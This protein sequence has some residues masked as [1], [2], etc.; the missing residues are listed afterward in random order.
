MNRYKLLAVLFYSVSAMP[1]MAQQYQSVW[2]KSEPEIT[3][4]IMSRTGISV[5]SI[6]ESL[7]LYRDILGMTPFYERTGLQDPRLVPFSGMTADQTMNLVVLRTETKGSA[8][9]HAGYIGLSEIREADGSIAKLPTIT[10]QQ[11]H[12]GS[13]T[14]MLIV[15]DT[16]IVY[17][18]VKKAGYKIIS[19]PKLNEDGS[20]TQLLMHGP[21]GERIWI[22]ESEMRS[23]FIGKRMD[24]PKP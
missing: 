23:P 15:E 10:Q 20:H 13:T 5:R 7:V 17:E 9:L 21:N 14:L 22:T 6:E 18:K 11:A 24:D 1:A 19:A 16:F 3:S 12:F 8:K 4:A 2:P